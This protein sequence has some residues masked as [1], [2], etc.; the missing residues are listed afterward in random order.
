[1]PGVAGNNGFNSYVLTA[2][3]AGVQIALVG[4]GA[5]SVA[6]VAPA[7]GYV[8]TVNMGADT[9]ANT[10]TLYDGTSTGGVV[11]AVLKVLAGIPASFALDVQFNVGL[12][13]VLAG[14][15]TPAVTIT[16]G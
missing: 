7:Q 15:T 12:Y 1:M 14:G 16:W 2:N 4:V 5:A 10:L 9:T 13:A 11:K 3:S 8:H 6:G